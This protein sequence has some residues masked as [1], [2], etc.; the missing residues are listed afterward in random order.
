M[1]LNNCL[2]FIIISNMP[3]S[4]R[5]LLLC[6]NNCIFYY[7][8]YLE[9]FKPEF[10]LKYNIVRT[11]INEFTEE[12]LIL[13]K[14]QI[15]KDI[16]LQEKELS[17]LGILYNTSMYIEDNKKLKNNKKDAPNNNDKTNIQ[18]NLSVFI[19]SDINSIDDKVK[20]CCLK[21]YSGEYSKLIQNNE[22]MPNL[23]YQYL[24]KSKNDILNLRIQTIRN[25][26]TISQ[27]LLSASVSIGKVV[28]EFIY[29]NNKLNINNYIQ[30]NEKELKEKVINQSEISKSKATSVLG[31]YLFNPYYKKELNNLIDLQKNRHEFLLNNIFDLQI[32]LLNYLELSS[33]DFYKRI[34]N[35]FNTF[36]LL[37]D[38]F[39]YEEEYIDLGDS[40]EFIDKRDFNFLLRLKENILNQASNTKDNKEKDID[41]NSKRSI[42]KE[43]LGVDRSKIKINYFDNMPNLI[44]K[45]KTMF[46]NIFDDLNSDENIVKS[47]VIENEFF[48]TRNFIKP[49]LSKNVIGNML[50]NNKNLSIERNFYYCK[51]FDKEF[52]RY[53]SHILGYYNRLINEE[54]LY[55]IKWKNSIKD[56][57]N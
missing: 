37:F 9:A 26:R 47:K 24:L 43:F 35:T 1:F 18:S 50:L 14:E 20:E 54:E 27:N 5:K 39:V 23:L 55:Y 7:G 29:E 33:E 31:P 41:L 21:C 56:L 34:V 10:T 38:N 25:L 49:Q 16:E 36:I 6:I 11:S 53:C 30:K 32:N 19:T 46:A 48:N 3:L 28:F 40:S 13:D 2:L 52:V 8:R 15:S 17:G 57:E 22:K 42:K 4:L 12:V 45:I 44:V 51:Y